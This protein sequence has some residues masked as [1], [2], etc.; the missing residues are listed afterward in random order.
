MFG[1]CVEAQLAWGIKQDMSG[2]RAGQPGV[3]GQFGLQ[4]A[5]IPA[6][7]AQADQA[8]VRAAAVG[9]AEQHIG[10]GTQGQPVVEFDCS[11]KVHA[12]RMQDKA[13]VDHDR[14]ATEDRHV[15]AQG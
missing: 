6:G 9:N 2:I 15:L 8:A 5:S 1:G 11:V 13:T 10:R 7:I 14:P 4:L 12:G 3:V